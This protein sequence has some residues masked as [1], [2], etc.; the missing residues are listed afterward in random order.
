MTRA[1]L[2]KFAR[3]LGKQLSDQGLEADRYMFR[4]Y[5]T[6]GDAII[7]GIQPQGSQYGDTRF[8]VKLALVLAPYWQWFRKKFKCPPEE[9][10]DTDVANWYTQIRATD[11]MD[12][13]GI[14]VIKDEDSIESVSSEVFSRLSEELTIALTW[15]DRDTLRRAAH[16]RRGRLWWSLR[17]WHLLE[18]DPPK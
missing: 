7:V 16:E 11:N 17:R 13:F 5:N 12:D 2:T 8:D 9:Q 15:L 4:R 14:W 3:A 10:P 1:V 6:E 18:E